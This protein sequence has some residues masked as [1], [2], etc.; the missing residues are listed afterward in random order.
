MP[1]PARLQLSGA[2]YHVTARGN[3]RER[4]FLD[5]RDYAR[6]LEY[7]A[8]VVGRFRWRCHAYCL[9]PNHFH[10]V[11][12]T[13]D[14]NISEGMQRLNGAYA[15]WFNRRHGLTGHV[16]QGRFHDVIVQ[17]DLHLLELCRYLPL[18]PVRARLCRHPNDWPWSSY[19]AA[20]S[21]E[22]PPSFLTVSWLLGWFGTEPDRAREVFRSF[23]ADAMPNARRP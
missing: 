1:R 3:R 15:Q 10:L 18:N 23:V 4:I 7:L 20:S 6:L 19:R 21:S 12:Q 2:T 17:S 14:A 5:D 11:I 9:M 16:F 22:P 13:A 8:V